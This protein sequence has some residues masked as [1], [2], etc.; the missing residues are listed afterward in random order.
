MP[1]E[2]LVTL[3][4]ITVASIAQIMRFQSK[5]KAML[6]GFAY[7][8]PANNIRRNIKHVT[9]VFKKFKTVN[10]GC[11]SCQ[12]IKTHITLIKGVAWEGG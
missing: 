6:R 4:T 11:E 7:D 10:F 3:A 2:G 12:A 5:Y 9:I 1:R 8:I